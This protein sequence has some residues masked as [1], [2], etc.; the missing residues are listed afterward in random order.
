MAASC[1]WSWTQVT[2]DADALSIKHFELCG[3]GAVESVLQ[4]PRKQLESDLLSAEA[5]KRRRC[6]D[7][8]DALMA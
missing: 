5:V 2:V 6:I 8:C 3:A 7:R 1:R 4:N